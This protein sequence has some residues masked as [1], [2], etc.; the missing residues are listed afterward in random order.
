MSSR[1]FLKTLR[2]HRKSFMWWNVGA[3]LLVAFLVAF[4]PSIESMEG[5]DEL[6]EQYPQDLMALLGAGDMAS[7]STPA[8]YL[9]A[10]LFGFMLPIILVV[11]AIARGSGAIAGE[12][13]AGTME[14]LISQPIDRGRLVLEKYASMVVSMLGLTFTIW[15]VL[16][17]GKLIINMDISVLR[18]AEMTFSLTLLGLAFGSVA[19]AVGCVTGR[20][21]LST[22]VT[23]SCV[24]AT[25][26]LNAM[27]LIVDAMEPAKWLSPFHYYNGSSPLIHG[28]NPAYAAALLAIVLTCL[29]VAYS[30]FRRRDIRT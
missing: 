23:A 15:L 5:L 26:I 30:G 7:I 18:L 9:N 20:Y 14:M 28:L 17:L 8:G 27:S 1:V 16:A 2:D 24:A 3:G 21:G 11:F 12:E 29:A 22:G 19:F 25:W 10:E 4:Y 6:V 13:R